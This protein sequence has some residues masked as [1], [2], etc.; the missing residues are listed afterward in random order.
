[1]L[2]VVELCKQYER[3]R[4]EAEQAAIRNADPVNVDNLND[5]EGRGSRGVVE[6]DVSPLEAGIRV[7]ISTTVRAPVVADH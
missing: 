4:L 5:M 2:E 3:E 1:M 7:R 6:R